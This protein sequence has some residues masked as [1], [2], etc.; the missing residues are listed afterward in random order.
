MLSTIKL[1]MDPISQPSRAVWSF[2]LANNIPIEIHQVSVRKGDCKKPDFLKINPQGQAPAIVDGDL[3]LPESHAILRYLCESQK[4]DE[5]WYPKDPKERAKVNWYLDF[6]HFTIRRITYYIF[7]S[8]KKPVPLDKDEEEKKFVPALDRIE[9][10]LLVNG[11][12]ISSKE[13]PTIADLVALPEIIQ[14]TPAGYD[15]SKYPRVQEWIK[16][17]TEIDAVS[18]T[19][20]EFLQFMKTLKF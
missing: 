12:F 13:K 20:E 3:A 11:K 8:F 17:M 9:N 5:S 15:M 7:S 4:V 14:L 1:Y 16:R 6:H 10:D 19:N 18:K 2:C